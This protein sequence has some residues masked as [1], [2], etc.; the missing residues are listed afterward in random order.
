MQLIIVLSDSNSLRHR[1]PAGHG[2]LYYGPEWTSAKK[3]FLVVLR[4]QT[5]LWKHIDHLLLLLDSLHLN[6]H[7]HQR[8]TKIFL[9][10]SQRG[11]FTIT[12][13]T[14][15]NSSVHL[16]WDGTGGPGIVL[17]LKQIVDFVIF[18]FLRRFSLKHFYFNCWL[19]DACYW[20][21]IEDE[22]C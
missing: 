11:V 13:L 15:L 10:E 17:Q 14:L 16:A 12:P 19:W 3:S 1:Q 21:W 5:T 20:G 6:E 7:Y 8:D 4:I 2:S 18:N 22:A 9:L